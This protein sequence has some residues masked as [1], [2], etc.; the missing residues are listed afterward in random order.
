MKLSSE[1][2]R[3]FHDDGYVKI[4]GGVSADLVDRAVKAINNSIGNGIDR[5]ELALLRSRSFCPELQSA[6]Q[7]TALYQES[8]LK[9]ICE[10]AI[11]NVAPGSGS[12]C[13]IALRFPDAGDQ[14]KRI[15]PHVDGTYSEHNG[16]K[17][18]SLS[19][20]SALCGVYLRDIVAPNNGNFMVWPGTHRQ[21]AS[22]LRTH[23]T[24]ALIDGMPPLDL[25]EPVQLSVK[26]GDVVLMHYLMAHSGA[27]NCGPNIRYAIYF[28]V[29]RAGH[30]NHRE[31]ALTDPWFEW[32]GLRAD[33]PEIFAA[34]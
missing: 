15:G 7:L 6:P 5:A 14:P 28:R 18:G 34:G 22:Y 13:Q 11:G 2:A 10:W 9:P 8:V 33:Y 29:S 3:Q 31:S 19:S 16:V 1:Q 4:E 21:L 12:H 20:F 17:K 26:S 24:D 30:A 32:D 25:P 27:S 23:G